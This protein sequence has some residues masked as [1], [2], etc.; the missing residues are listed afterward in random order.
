[1]RKALP[2]W[3]V[4]LLVAVAAGLWN[5]RLDEREE[6]ARDAA[7]RIGRLI[8]SEEGKRLEIAALSVGPRGGALLR[9]A[10]V[11]GIW[12]CLDHFGA[13]AN[14]AA[15]DALLQA[16][17]DAEGVVS[18]ADAKRAA[19]YGIGAAGAWIVRLHGPLLPRTPEENVLL[20][21]ELGRQNEAQ[22]GCFVRRSGQQV[23]WSIDTNPWSALL[24]GAAPNRP[25]LLDPCVVPRVVAEASRRIERVRVEHTGGPLLELTL[26]ELQV[27]EEDLRRGKPSFAWRLSADGRAV[28][29]SQEAAA[30]Y[31]SFLMCAPYERIVAALDE[32]EPG[33]FVLRATISLCPAEG[34]PLELCIGA[35]DE[36][37][38][39]V[40]DNAAAACR[41]E[42]SSEVAALL[43]PR[44]ELLAASATAAPWKPWLR[45]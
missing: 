43:A 35:P 40:I 45:R 17:L 1:M 19:D 24:M 27:T 5:G 22:D 42:V 20:E 12:R 3:I 6:E 41:Y 32:Q 28:E 18:S 23:V 29:A 8:P 34:E 31:Y 25:L 33:A 21:V 26:V 10:P 44:A 16:L 13:V 14:M 30:A 39:A 4:L 2:A 11:G 36:R 15:I 38:K 9:Y 37:G 7:E